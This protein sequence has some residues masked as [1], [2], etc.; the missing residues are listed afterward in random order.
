MLFCSTAD[1]CK[2]RSDDSEVDVW[3]KMDVITNK[4]VAVLR[5]L[6][7]HVHTD[8]THISHAL[9]CLCC[10]VQLRHWIRP[11]GSQG[12]LGVKPPERFWKGD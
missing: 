12:A 4:T 7:T 1:W 11:V 2:R 5:Y 10:S 6:L 9:Y 8:A 3:L